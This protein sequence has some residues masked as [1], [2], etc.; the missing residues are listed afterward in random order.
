MDQVVRVGAAVAA[1]LLLICGTIL[2]F[3]GLEAGATATYAA[4]ILM[5][6]F[7]FLSRFKKFKG[8]GIEA[9]LWEEKQ[10]EA[11]MLIDRLKRLS[12]A[13]AEPV[14]AMTARMG[15]LDSHF[16]RREHSDVLSRLE[17][18]LREAGVDAE[19][20]EHMKSDWYNYNT[21][22][23]TLP[24]SKTLIAAMDERKKE[25]HQ[26]S[27][28]PTEPGGGAKKMGQREAHELTTALES[29]KTELRAM[30]AG[31]VRGEKAEVPRKLTDWFERLPAFSDA[32]RQELR[33]RLKEQMDD[34]AFY[35]QH[36]TFRRPEIWF[37]EDE[38]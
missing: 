2:A 22:D 10:E 9:E 38:D 4:A 14:I 21:F 24:I 15:R 18:A 31:I 32:E 11:A 25:L 29:A 20:I 1:G 27:T 12:A 19:D 17:G 6:I 28:K 33:D 7:V 16:S 23:L 36:R 13:T 34:L 26:E 8:F 3:R 35:I 30:F 37:A 5:L